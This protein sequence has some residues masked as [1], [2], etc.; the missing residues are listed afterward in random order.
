VIDI[1]YILLY[2]NYI[3]AITSRLVFEELTK[4]C[5]LNKNYLALLNNKKLITGSW[6]QIWIGCKMS[7]NALVRNFEEKTKRM[8]I[9]NRTYISFCTFWPPLGTPLGQSRKYYMDGNG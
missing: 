1:C 8:A 7:K 4:E 2:D 6:I 3:C 9:A 5:I